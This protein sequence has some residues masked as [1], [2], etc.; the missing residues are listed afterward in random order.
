MSQR[1][2]SG[3][4]L[5]LGPHCHSSPSELIRGCFQSTLCR[6]PSWPLPWVPSHSPNTS[7][8][9]SEV[10]LYSHSFPGHLPVPKLV[11]P[12]YFISCYHRVYLCICCL[13]PCQ[14][15]PVKGKL[16]GLFTAPRQELVC[17]RH[18]V[19]SH[20]AKIGGFLPC[21]VVARELAAASN[22]TKPP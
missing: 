2:T 5:P 3:P 21:P 20:W 18:L 14:G 19:N 10:A 7:S 12:P 1:D 13:K 4:S 16:L 8:C 22:D 11:I 17:S 6:H 15:E 9:S